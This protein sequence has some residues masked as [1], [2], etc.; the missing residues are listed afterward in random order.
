MKQN[1][2]YSRSVCT[3][4]VLVYYLS[5]KKITFFMLGTWYCIRCLMN[6]FLLITLFSHPLQF[7]AHLNCLP[8]FM[9]L[10]MLNIILNIFQ[11]H[12]LLV[13]CKMTL[14]DSNELLFACRYT[15]SVPIWWNYFTWKRLCLYITTIQHIYWLMIFCEMT[16]YDSLHLH[17][18]DR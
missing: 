7:R 3:K 16:L 5:K 4:F 12:C 6:F 1:H 2:N 11:M 14:H 18:P 13:F 8:H 15:C 17:S 10:S 9:N